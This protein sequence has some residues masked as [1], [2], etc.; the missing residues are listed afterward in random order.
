M[1]RSFM[2]LVI[3]RGILVTAAQIL[4]LITFFATTGHLYWYVVLSNN[5]YETHTCR[6]HR[7]AIHITTTKLYINTFC[8][9]SEITV[10]ALIPKR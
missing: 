3:T 9:Y 6:T 10:V 2:H 1:L 4:L 5:T 7:L 8:Q